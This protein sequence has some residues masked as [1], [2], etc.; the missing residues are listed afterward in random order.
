M[1]TLRDIWWLYGPE[2]IRFALLILV[3]C[4]LFLAGYKAGK[5]HVHVDDGSCSQCHEL[6][7]RGYEQGMKDATTKWSEW[8]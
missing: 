1:K 2:I 5:N 7:D 4:G 8:K 3:V 6:Y